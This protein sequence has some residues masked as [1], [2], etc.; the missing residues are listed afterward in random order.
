MRPLRGGR[1]ATSKRRHKG[2][3]SNGQVDTR[4]PPT[5][6]E[7]LPSPGLVSPAQYLPAVPTLVLG[8][9]TQVGRP[10]VAGGQWPRSPSS[11]T[12]PPLPHPMAPPEP[13]PAPAAV[14]ED[15]VGKTRLRDTGRGS[16]QTE[17]PTSSL[18]SP[19]PRL[20]QATDISPG[21]CSRAHLCSP[22]PMPLPTQ[23]QEDP[24]EK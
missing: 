20:P 21:A 5:R 9:G 3:Q 17:R 16:P 6:W 24:C 4:W 14:L 2:P 23:H 15:G 12:R 19:L 13:A 10:R 22:R 11:V 7:A 18:P 1:R 8:V